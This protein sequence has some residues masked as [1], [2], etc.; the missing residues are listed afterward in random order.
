MKSKVKILMIVASLLLIGTFF[1]PLWSIDLKAP[2]YPEGLGMYIYL[3]KLAGHKDGDLNSING[4]NHY[5]GMKVID[6][7]SIPEL[8]IMPYFMIF[9]IVF[10]LIISF[11]PNYKLKIVWL[12]IF[13]IGGIVGLYD[14]YQWE[15]DYGHDLDPKAIIKIPGMS[16]QPPLIG[17]KQLLN[18]EAGSWPH[19]GFAI[20]AVSLILVVFTIFL[21]V[22]N[23]KSIIKIK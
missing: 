18:F 11:I 17:V 19:F 5:I 14:F 15:Y 4:L 7:A 13:A 2:Q 16:Y 9:M 3:N 1:V 6:P 10:G 22:K 12:A 20:I 23:E 8:E 21:Q